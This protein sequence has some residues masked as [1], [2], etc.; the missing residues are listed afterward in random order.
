MARVVTY[1]NEHGYCFCQVRLDSGERVLI[2]IAQSGIQL[3]RLALGGLV[4]RELVAEWPVAHL[5]EAV[6]LFADPARPSQ[7]PLDTIKDK[8]LT[9]QSLAD[10]RE[11]LRRR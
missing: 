5:R 7:H 3:R 8:L 4:P 6:D 9:M 10:L 11:F 2:S 1:R